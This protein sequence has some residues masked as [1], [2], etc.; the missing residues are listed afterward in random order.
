V[1]ARPNTR[2]LFVRRPDRRGRPQLRAYAATSLAGEES[3]RSHAIESY[4]DLR[5]LDLSSGGE[6]LDSPLFIVCTH[7]K[8]DP[9]CARYGRPVF[10]A[11]AEQLDEEWVWQST[12]V[13]GDRFAGNVVCLPHGVYYGRLDR[14]DAIELLDEHLAERVV[15]DKYR[16]RSI[17][18]FGEQAAERGIREREQILELD[19]LQ[20]VETDGVHAIFRDV[21]G[22]THRLTIVA[23]QGEPRRLTCTAAEERRPWR[24][25][26]SESV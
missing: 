16:G 13:G 12:H 7:G 9:C 25:R 6:L 10:E 5:A 19:G 8:H 26:V 17:F 22:H 18:T 11:L 14:E 21:L 1:R 3:L 2:L 4:E 20:L 24:F 15:L 23:E